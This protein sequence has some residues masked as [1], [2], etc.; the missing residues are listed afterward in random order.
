MKNISTALLLMTLFLT[1]CSKEEKSIAKKLEGRWLEQDTK[2]TIYADTSKYLNPEDFV[3]YIVFSNIKYNKG[4]YHYEIPNLEQDAL[5]GKAKLTTENF[6]A[7]EKTAFR[8]SD[9]GKTIEM[10]SNKTFS[11]IEMNL[12]G[13]VLTLGLSHS[14]DFSKQ[15]YIKE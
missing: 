5:T 14:I 9:E 13:E 11:P 3:H 12:D 15:T 10:K 1:A 6:Y 8:I 4:F 7:T 2:L